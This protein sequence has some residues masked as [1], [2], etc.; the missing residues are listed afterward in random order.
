MPNSLAAEALNTAAAL[1]RTRE[2][3][4]LSYKETVYDIGESLVFF[5]P[6]KTGLASSN[7][8]V[9]NSGSK[10]LER[11]V[12]EGVKGKAS[13]EAISRSIPS[14][15]F[16]KATI[17]NNPVDYIDDLEKGTSPQAR[18]GMV[19]PTKTRINDLWLKNLRKNK[20]I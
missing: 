18:A 3:L 10:S 19:T 8:G 20:I 17:F 15:D 5:T 14:L 12:K 4:V 11:E 13:L 2:S 16:S 1:K 6:L 7:W 9:S